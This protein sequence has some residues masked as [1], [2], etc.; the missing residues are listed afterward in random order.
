MAPGGR[1][2]LGQ[3]LVEQG[4]LTPEGLA[5]ALEEQRRTGAA[6]RDVLLKLDLVPERA[7]LDYYEDQLGIPVMDLTTYAL[8]PD[9]VRLVPERVA[10]QFHVVP[11]FK[12]GNTITVAMADPLDFVAIDEVKQSTGLQVDV[13]VSSG[14][15]IREAVERHHPVSGGLDQLAKEQGLKHAVAEIANARPE[16]D[17]P[18]IRFVN[19]IVQ[20]ALR[21]GA[22]DLHFEPDESSFRIRYRVDGVLREVSVQAKTIYS[23]VVSRVKVMATLDISERR[24]PQDGRI[25]MNLLGRDLDVRV[26]TF[27]TIH[28]EN[29]VMRIL[30]RSLALVGLEELGLFPE[31]LAI[32]ARMI[33]RPNGI[34]LVTGPTGSGKTTTLYSCIQRINTVE[35]NIVTLEDPV[36]Y[37]LGS[38]RQTQVDPDVG[39]TFARGLRALL[40]QDPDVILVGE[41]RDG[42]TAEIAVRSALT[43]H[44]VLSTLHTNDASGAIPRLTDMKI[45]PFLLSSAMVGV[46]AQRLV[47]RI[48]DKCKKKVK[49][50]ADLLAE[51]GIQRGEGSFAHGAGCQTCGGTGYHG[52][53]GIFEVL[54]VNDKVRDLISSR[55]SAEDLARAV[56]AGGTGSLR[57]DAIRKAAH[58]ITT[59]EEALRVTNPD[60]ATLDQ[61]AAPLSYPS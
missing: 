52:R 30:D 33:E 12:I 25:R 49:P 13:V 28:G 4:S 35:R 38:I 16:E 18:I 44:L 32:V 57:E 7:I 11:L 39:L 9:V 21:D 56:R 54:E 46:L 27:P 43:G 19:T 48:C 50:P 24:L 1:K 2:P 29:V 10:R 17:G 42:E 53:V 3:C 41:I 51:L 6:L 60:A 34:V 45:E 58:G 31:P 47:R 40:R 36:E 37:H 61:G 20:Q 5:R 26:S 8:E 22:S 15:Q 14:A 59:L 55:A 23:S